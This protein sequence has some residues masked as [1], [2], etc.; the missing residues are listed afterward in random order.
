MMCA[1]WVV[2]GLLAVGLVAATGSARADVGR[3]PDLSR[4][5]AVAPGEPGGERDAAL[6]VSVE[7]YA[8]LPGIPGAAANAADWHR[9]LTEGRRVPAERVRLLRDNEGTL[10]KLRRFARE[11]AAQVQ[12]GGTLWFVFIGHGAPA[13]D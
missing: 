1:R 5:P 12:P 11:A 10:E 9:Y 6:I 8:E 13:A 4:P 3:W 7:R 2:R